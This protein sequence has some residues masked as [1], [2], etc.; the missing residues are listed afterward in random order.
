MDKSVSKLWNVWR[1]LVTNDGLVAP[2]LLRHR[3]SNH[4]LAQRVLNLVW[5]LMVITSAAAFVVAQHKSNGIMVVLVMISL[6][7]YVVQRHLF[8]RLRPQKLME[9]LPD[10][11]SDC[12]FLL[13]VPSE[14]LLIG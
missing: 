9:N 4:Y 10:L 8:Q 5:L 11:L 2:L 7:V 13:V 6:F 1:H 12:S 3:G 14:Y